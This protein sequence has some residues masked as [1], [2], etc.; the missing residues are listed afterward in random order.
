MSTELK[1]PLR[2]WNVPGRALFAI[3]HKVSYRLL[4]AVWRWRRWRLVA[5]IR[6]RAWWHRSAVDIN[7]AKDLQVGRGIRIHVET[8]TSSRITVGPRGLW[9][10]GLR[11][12]L[13]GGSLILGEGVDIR[14]LCVFQ[15][16]GHLEFAGPNLIQHG[17]TLNCDER[18]VL[19]PRSSL[20]EYC[21]VVDS[22]HRQGGP[23]GWFLHD[24][25][26]SP[27][28]LGSDVW[29]ATKATITRGVNIGEAAIVAA[30][31]VVIRTVPP[32]ALVS[33]VP[34]TEIVRRPIGAGSETTSTLSD[35]VV[36]GD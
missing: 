22:T 7:V 19:G 26:T 11:V 15:V 1:R 6:F 34:A 16:T 25:E 20:G 14:H 33:G 31:S 36:S 4:L 23:S 27:I 13:R 29:V 17:C 5:G 18:I 30:N 9:G 24:L 10:D 21:S 32:G 35:E 3:S 2:P 12:D 8:R 28:V